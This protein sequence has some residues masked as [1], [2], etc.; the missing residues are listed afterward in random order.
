MF[1]VILNEW[2][3]KQLVRLGWCVTLVI[4]GPLFWL[5]AFVLTRKWWRDRKEKGVLR[6]GGLTNS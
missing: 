1:L 3:N 6:V 5:I 2:L 4:A